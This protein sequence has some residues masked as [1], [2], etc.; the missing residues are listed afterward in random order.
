MGAHRPYLSLTHKHFAKLLNRNQKHTHEGLDFLK[1]NT[2]TKRWWAIWPFYLLLICFW[3]TMASTGHHPLPPLH[4]WPGAVS[5]YLSLSLKWC[6]PYNTDMFFSIWF[7][8]N[9]GRNRKMDL[10]VLGFWEKR[11]W[12]YI[13]EREVYFCK[14]ACGANMCQKLQLWM[15]L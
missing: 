9:Q 8:P 3:L 1:T 11:A 2:Q 7:K 10:Q 12:P 4:P 13:C 15:S 6:F 5:S 14:L